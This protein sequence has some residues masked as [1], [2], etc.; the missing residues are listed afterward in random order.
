MVANT[1]ASDGGAA[2]VAGN[3]R[4]LRARLWDARFFWDQDRKSPLESRLPALERMVFHAELGSQG[5]R[6][7]RLVALA[8]ALVPQ[9]AGC[10]S[11]RWRERAALLAKADLVTGMVGEFPELQGIMGG[12]YARAQGEPAAVAEADPRPLRAQGT[13][14]TL[15]ER[16][17]ERR[18]GAGRQARHAGRASSP[19][20]SGRPAPRTRSR[21]RRAGLGI[22]RLILENGLRLPLRRDRSRQRWPA[23]A[24]RFRGVAAAASASELLGVPRR[25]AQGPSARAGRAPRHRSPQCSPSAAEDDLVRLIA[26]AEALQAFLDSEDGRNLLAAYRRASSIVGIEEKKDGRSYNGHPVSGALV[27]PGRGR[28]CTQALERA[29]GAIDRALA[30][31]GLYP[32]HDRT[33]RLARRRSTASSKPSW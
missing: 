28:L 7:E 11:R 30:E 17:G 5:Q 31:R 1:V 22:I 15:P 29:Q 12:H 23:T 9:C 13:R 25:P 10:R 14:T 27:E 32:G 24:S 21:L 26:R 20:T 4:V 19:P 2:I 3:E 8:G 18:R 16:A 6:V 33:R